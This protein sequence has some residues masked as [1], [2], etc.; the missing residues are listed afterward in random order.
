MYKRQRWGK[1]PAVKRIRCHEEPPADTFPNGI[2]AA[3]SHTKPATARSY[4]EI[5][6]FLPRP[7]LSATPNHISAVPVPALRDRGSPIPP[8]GGWVA[9]PA[10][11]LSMPTPPAHAPCGAA[12]HSKGGLILAGWCKRLPL[13]SRRDRGARPR[14]VAVSSAV[15]SPQ[16]AKC[17]SPP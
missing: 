5:T 8:A 14:D 10:P 9:V 11:L 7:R 3:R 17:W 1:S 4:R 13:L 16:P 2:N 6:F 12:V 15:A